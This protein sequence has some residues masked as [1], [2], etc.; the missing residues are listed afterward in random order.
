M[1][2]YASILTRNLPD[3]KFGN[4]C[5][6]SVKYI[7]ELKCFCTAKETINKIKR[8]PI[9]WENIF[10][11]TSDKGLTYKIFYVY[12]TYSMTLMIKEKQIETMMRYHLTLVR[13]VIINK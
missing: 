12:K 8:Q 2:T 5:S 11:D 13:M 10:A 7:I 3:I 6:S 9:E 1:S 4:I